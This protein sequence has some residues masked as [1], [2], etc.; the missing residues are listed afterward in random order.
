MT[1]SYNPSEDEMIV[2]FSPGPVKGKPTKKL[3]PYQMWCDH[4]GNIDAFV[5]ESYTEKLK[6]FRKSLKTIRLG[7]IWEG[8]K[9]TNE[10]IQETREE[11]LKM[12]EEK[13]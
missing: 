12:L 13:W 8:V 11:L 3:G 6:E 4:N 7:G 10:D 9:I 5:M 2:K 1:V